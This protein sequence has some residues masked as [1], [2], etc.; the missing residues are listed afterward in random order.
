MDKVSI[1]WV[2]DEI[3][4][5]KPHIIFLRDKGYT[6]ETVNSGYDALDMIKAKQ[7][8]ILFSWMNRCP[9]YRALRL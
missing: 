7:F 8:N 1:L 5:L 9:D 4:L 3:D 6:V 2:D